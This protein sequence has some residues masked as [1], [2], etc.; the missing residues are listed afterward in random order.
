MELRNR[1]S[2][3]ERLKARYSTLS[4]SGSGEEQ[5]SQ[6]YYVIQAAQKREELVRKGDEYDHKIRI[7]E[8]EIRALQTTLDH[9]NARNKAFR[10]S[11]QKVELDGDDMQ[12]GRF[13]RFSYFYYCSIK[14]FSYLLFE[15]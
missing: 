2:N 11:F 1:E 13:D 10:A 8:K 5:H 3:V 4:G 7:A 15:F 6:A 9:L 12:V 14:I